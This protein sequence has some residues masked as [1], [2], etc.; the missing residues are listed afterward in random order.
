VDLTDN[1]SMDYTKNA[2]IGITHLIVLKPNL[3]QF[4]TGDKS[5][6]CLV[7]IGRLNGYLELVE[8]SVQNGY[9]QLETLRL[10]HNAPLINI[11]YSGDYI[12]VVGQ[13]YT[14]KVVKFN[15]SHSSISYSEP[16]I[17]QNHVRYLTLMFEL[18]EHED[19]PITSMCIDKENCINAATGSQNGLICVWNL[20]T[21]ECKLK[22]NK[23]KSKRLFYLTRTL[24]N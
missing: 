4:Q 10:C 24:F 15:S 22:L 9:S 6:S 11:I 5:L 23:K 7:L 17:S 3:R 14:L 12:L 2:P 1:T 18:N 13:D 20:F 19:S 16:T 8:F 21:G